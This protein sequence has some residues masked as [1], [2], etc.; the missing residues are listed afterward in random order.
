MKHQS[1]KEKKPISDSPAAKS[2]L[3]SLRRFSRNHLGTPTVTREDA[4]DAVTQASESNLISGVGIDLKD[5]FHNS[6]NAEEEIISSF[7][8]EAAT[9]SNHPHTVAIKQSQLTARTKGQNYTDRYF[10]F[11]NFCVVVK[12]DFVTFSE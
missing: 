3:P 12:R 9:S 5:D 7:S 10:I 8:Q 2:A 11:Y 4:N 1:N 6:I